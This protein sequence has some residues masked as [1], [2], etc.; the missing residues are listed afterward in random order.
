MYLLTTLNKD[1]KRVSMHGVKEELLD[2][3]AQSIGIPLLKVWVS[4]G[5]Y[6]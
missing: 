1:L 2:L 6:E 3:Q 5:S 4:E